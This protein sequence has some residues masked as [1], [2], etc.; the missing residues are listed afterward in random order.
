MTDFVDQ[1]YLDSK[2]EELNTYTDAVESRLQSHAEGEVDEKHVKRPARL[3]V[4]AY[5]ELGE[6]L[7]EVSEQI[8]QHDAINEFEGLLEKQGYSSGAEFLA[9]QTPPTAG[10]E[11]PERQVMEEFVENDWPDTENAYDARRRYNEVSIKAQEEHGI[12]LPRPDVD[13]NTEHREIIEFAEEE[14]MTVTEAR[15]E[16]KGEDPDL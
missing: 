9:G 2:A 6:T 3:A 4:E 11:D 14:G 5:E 12:E 15:K 7:D 1:G 10:D 13:I 8:Q 16:V